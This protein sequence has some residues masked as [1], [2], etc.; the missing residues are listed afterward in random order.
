VTRSLPAVVSVLAVVL[1]GAACSSRN[2]PTA[3]PRTAAASPE[4]PEAPVAPGPLAL[5]S[6]PPLPGDAAPGW[7]GLDEDAGAAPEGA[8]G[9]APA[10]RHGVHHGGDRAR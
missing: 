5:A 1:V 7:E 2:V 4:A 8:S 9:A 10:H 6:D 3:W